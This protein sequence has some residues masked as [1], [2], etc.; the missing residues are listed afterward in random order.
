MSAAGPPSPAQVDQIISDTQALAYV[1]VLA[2]ALFVYD[3]LLTLNDEI[4]YIWKPRINPGTILYYLARYA[5]LLNTFLNVLFGFI[6]FNIND[7]RVCATINSIL[8]VCF[9]LSFVGTHGLLTAR[10]YALYYSNMIVSVILV[11]LMT[12]GVIPALIQTVAFSKCDLTPGQQ[13]LLSSPRL[14]DVRSTEI[15]FLNSTDSIAVLLSLSA[16]SKAVPPRCIGPPPT[17][18][19]TSVW[20]ILIYAFIHMIRLPVLILC[21]FSL[22]LRQQNSATHSPSPSQTGAA[23]RD[24][25]RTEPESTENA[26]ATTFSQSSI[27][28]A[29]QYIHNE[30]VNE[31]DERPF[32]LNMVDPNRPN[33][34]EVDNNLG[35][36][37]LM[38][39]VDFGE[40]RWSN[41]GGRG[42]FSFSNADINDPKYN[43]S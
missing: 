1:N 26:T 32:D 21:R 19:G 24:Q 23:S 10:A 20:R 31:F 25:A 16:E 7:A 40:F 4:Q 18:V 9:I 5:G 43:T 33:D 38:L 6:P 2:L 39:K 12:G 13:I 34:I 41:N 28:R 8:N 27:Q 22:Y 35:G 17:N 15:I 42:L 14:I 3:T 11:G 30:L 29:V 36:R 37:S